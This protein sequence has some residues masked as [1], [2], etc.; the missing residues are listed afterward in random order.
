LIGSKTTFGM[1]RYDL[2]TIS[3]M[4]VGAEAGTGQLLALDELI[5]KTDAN[6]DCSDILPKQR[7]M[8]TFKGKRYGS[9]FRRTST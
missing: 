5:G 4:W 2:F 1:A 6:L 3:N 8:F 7:G 9:P